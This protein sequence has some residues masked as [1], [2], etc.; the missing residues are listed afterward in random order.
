MQFLYIV[1]LKL[2]EKYISRLLIQKIC[3][4][5]NLIKLF[6]FS[7]FNKDFIYH[8]GIFGKYCNVGD[9]ILYEQIERIFDLYTNR[10]NKWYNRLAVGE[11][12]SLEVSLINKYCPLLVVGGH[13]LLMPDSN[14]NN[15]SGW[16]FNIK[17]KNL[18][19]INIPVVFFAIGYNVFRNKET[20]IPIFKEHLTECVQKS[21][22]FGLRNYG[23]INRIKTYLPEQL[24]SKIKYQPCSATILQQEPL[25]EPFDKKE[26]AIVT[27]FN[28]INYR[29]SISLSNILEQL[30]KYAIKMQ[31]DGFIVN[32]YGH[33]LFDTHGKCYN[34]L[35]KNGFRTLPLFK[36]KKNDIYNL[37]KQNKLVVSMR[38]HG[39]MIPFGFSLP[40]ISLTTQDKQK[41]FLETIGHPDWNID[42]NSDFFSALVQ[43]TSEIM[44]N[45]GEIQ[46]N[47]IKQKKVNQNITRENMEFIVSNLNGK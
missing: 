14:K 23:S 7:R 15:N 24:H 29:Y 38:G 36:Y 1:S 18:K 17:I 35:K 19:K 20:F 22:F 47:L 21:L 42:V 44:N 31:D 37:Y 33:H 27:A 34:Y 5:L 13:G 3:A 26:I 11:V 25:Y 45:Y 16:G 30:L 6:I 8:Y 28:K 40:A 46:K 9:G 10:K 2:Y 39:L 32:F 41:W 12:T 4:C 43:K